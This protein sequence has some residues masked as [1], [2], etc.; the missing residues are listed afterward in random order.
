MKLT[1]NRFRLSQSPISTLNQFLRFGHIL[2]EQCVVTKE[3]SDKDESE[4]DCRYATVHGWKRER[5]EKRKN[6]TA[7]VR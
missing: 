7:N 4:G 6:L 3:Q 5:D 1:F 2:L